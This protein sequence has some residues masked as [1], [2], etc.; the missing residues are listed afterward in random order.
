[1]TINGLFNNS[2]PVCEG[3]LQFSNGL[4]GP[5]LK[6]IQCSRTVSREWAAEMLASISLGGNAKRVEQP[7]S[8]AFRQAA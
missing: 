4:D 7:A 5:A 8:R 6:C 1:M 2:C 3:D